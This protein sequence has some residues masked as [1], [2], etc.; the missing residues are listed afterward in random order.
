[1]I[2]AMILTVTCELED[3]ILT[4]IDYSQL[5][6]WLRFEPLFT[7][8]LLIWVH[9]LHAGDLWTFHWFVAARNTGSRILWC[10]LK[11]VLIDWFEHR[12]LAR[13][14]AE[15]YDTICK[16]GFIQFRP[17]AGLAP[18]DLKWKSG[19][20]GFPSV[21]WMQTLTTLQKSRVGRQNKVGKGGS[22]QGI[23]GGILKW[24]GYL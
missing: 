19:Q 14:G 22:G 15:L 6:T 12:G 11:I 23:G 18:V 24:A 13:F 2:L 16:D 20:I 4:V 17:K 7:G 21:L 3:S 5:I 1:M 10:Y 9:I 8:H